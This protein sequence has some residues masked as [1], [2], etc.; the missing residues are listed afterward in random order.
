MFMHLSSLSSLSLWQVV[1]SVLA[2][3]LG[4]QTHSNYQHDF[5]QAKSVL[6]FIIVGIVMVVILVAII[7]GIALLITG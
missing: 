1:K 7:L 3:F 2:S 5:T 6:P 4:V